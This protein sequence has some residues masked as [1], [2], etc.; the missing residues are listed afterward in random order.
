M[1]SELPVSR[2]AER[3]AHDRLVED[4]ARRD[5]DV[6]KAFEEAHERLKRR[7]DAARPVG[8]LSLDVERRPR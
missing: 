8:Q 2:E 6:A 7:Y 5:R 1:P 4:I 3:R